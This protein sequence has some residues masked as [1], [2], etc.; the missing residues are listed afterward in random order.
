M[1]NIDKKSL[2]EGTWGHVSLA[3]IM[4][5]ASK[6]ATT[7]VE[8]QAY[9]LMGIFQVNMPLIYGEGIKAF[10]R[11]QVEIMKYSNDESI[12]AWSPPRSYE[13]SVRSPGGIDGVGLLATSPESFADSYGI[14]MP[15]TAI[16]NGTTYDTEKQHIRLS[17]KIVK[18]WELPED[19][20][21]RW[22]RK[23]RKTKRQNSKSQKLVGEVFIRDTLFNGIR[24]GISE[25]LIVTQNGD[26]DID[27]LEEVC[28][29]AVLGCESENGFVALPVRLYPTG[30]Y[31]RFSGGFPQWYEVQWNPM[32]LL[33]GAGTHYELRDAPSASADSTLS[34][35]D[36]TILI[37][38]EVRTGRRLQGW[39]PSR[40]GQEI[41][42][43]T[44]SLTSPDT[45]YRLTSTYP[46]DLALSI[47]L[48]ATQTCC[49]IAATLQEVRDDKKPIMKEAVLF[50]Q[51]R[52]S[53][54][55]LL[56]FAIHLKPI[57]SRSEYIISYFV[58][59]SV[60]NWSS[61]SFPPE[62]FSF[63]HVTPD[64]DTSYLSTPLATDKSIVFRPRR[65]WPGAPDFVSVSIEQR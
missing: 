33:P 25:R 46:Q 35:L 49:T 65:R 59:S 27:N 51:N 57:T 48:T 53:R 40:R 17:T 5:W 43:D 45:D 30:E 8:D 50:F 12:F 21:L 54:T 20:C 62:P 47:P 38:A 52:G 58:G 7:R 36:R 15:S 39:H 18:L 3:G 32:E 23:G 14:C 2:L 16:R 42:F 61:G 24:K 19:G 9:S 28:L 55:D 10:Y 64:G 63:R 29:L 56:P 4:S 22:K 11:L 1:T 13:E 44:E 34:P 26:V 60:N 31:G 6:W 37:R 41:R